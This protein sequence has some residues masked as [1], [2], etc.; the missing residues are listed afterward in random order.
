MYIR[1]SERLI[2]LLHDDNNIQNFNIKKNRTIRTKSK[3]LS[4]PQLA[5]PDLRSNVSPQEV[6]A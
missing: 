1:V 6:P 3:T 5:F 2:I 4:K